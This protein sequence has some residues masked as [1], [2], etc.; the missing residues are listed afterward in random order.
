MLNSILKTL[1][2]SI[3]DEVG[4]YGDSI[5]ECYGNSKFAL[6]KPRFFMP[7]E[8]KIDSYHFV[9]PN[10]KVP[11]IIV[12]SMECVLTRK[13]IFPV[14]PGQIIRLSKANETANAFDQFKYWVLFIEKEYLQSLAKSIFGKTEILYFENK[15][16]QVNKEFINL[17]NTFCYESNNKQIGYEFILESL[18]VQ[19]SA[20]ILRTLKSNMSYDLNVRSYTTRS[21]VNKI[22]DYMWENTSNKFALKD[23]S[24]IVNLSPYYF[25]RLFKNTT[26]KTPCDYFMDIK[27]RKAMEHLR[28]GK[29]Y[30]TEISF[31]LGFSSHSHFSYIFKSR[32]GVTPSE[33][34]KQ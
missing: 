5:L 24:K 26:G 3:P 16:S 29:Y 23:L 4:C 22:I 27:I 30:V 17:L 13:K 12:D 25:I 6:T 2:V 32:V 33:F 34:L 7:G 14:N 21:E 11:S 8:S 9:I 20:I 1:K 31:M 10:I 28:S 19:I 18:I 15:N